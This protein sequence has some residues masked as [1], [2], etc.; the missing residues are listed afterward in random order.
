MPTAAAATFSVNAIQ[1]YFPQSGREMEVHFVSSVGALVAGTVLGQVTAS[2][3]WN[4][5]N[6]GNANGTEVA[7]AILKHDVFVDANG[8][9][10]FGAQAG[11]DSNGVLH[12]S[13][14]A[15]FEG[16]FR[17]TE[18]TGLDAAGI[19]DLGRLISGVLADGILKVT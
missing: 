4:A 9:V 17:T 10:T 2:G 18:L 16:E 11:G 3:L 1:P 14:P 19:T 15:Y 6:N 7:K 12:E 8:K 5:Y 13:A